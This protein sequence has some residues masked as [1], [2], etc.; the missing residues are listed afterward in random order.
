MCK[1]KKETKREWGKKGKKVATDWGFF[2]IEIPA[3]EK[4]EILVEQQ[5]CGVVKFQEA[6][7]IQPW[8]PGC[9]ACNIISLYIVHDKSE[10]F[11]S[12]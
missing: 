10:F 7:R 8:N 1:L 4:W 5:G 6:S 9:P 2:L 3:S 11:Q 12:P